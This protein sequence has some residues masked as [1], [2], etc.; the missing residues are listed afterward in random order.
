MKFKNNEEKDIAE[1]DFGII[2]VG[3]YTP[4]GGMNVT[5]VC[6]GKPIDISVLLLAE[7]STNEA[8]SDIVKAALK[9]HLQK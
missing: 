5:F 6:D 8:F 4:D 9:A 1:A 2:L 7:I 3:K